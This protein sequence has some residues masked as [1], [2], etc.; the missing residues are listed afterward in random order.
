MDVEKIPL[1]DAAFELGVSY[2]HAHRLMLTK[3]L[4]GERS[5]RGWQVTRASVDAYKRRVD[6]AAP[7]TPQAA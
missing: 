1:V 6:G 2:Q 5:G 7:T 3:R 4:E